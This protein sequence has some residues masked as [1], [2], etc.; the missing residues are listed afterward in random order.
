MRACVSGCS[1][2]EELL[3]ARQRVE[4]VRLKLMGME[5]RGLPRYMDVSSGAGGK[6][7]GE[8]EEVVMRGTHQ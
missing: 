6:G 8:V 7:G 4:E 1:G 3:V 2:A 5:A